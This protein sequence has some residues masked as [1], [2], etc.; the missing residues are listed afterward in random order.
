MGRPGIRGNGG[1]GRGDQ[2]QDNLLDAVVIFCT[3]VECQGSSSP[4][5]VRESLTRI[6]VFTSHAEVK[7]P[8]TIA[9]E[10]SG[11]VAVKM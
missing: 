7:M 1:V 4:F 8:L 6:S 3:T 2:T 5:V 9:I 11:Q 10:N